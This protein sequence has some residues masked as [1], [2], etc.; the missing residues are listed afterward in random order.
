M[1]AFSTNLIYVVFGIPLA[2][3]YCNTLL[4]NLNARM[5][6]RGEATTL[7]LNADAE[8]GTVS[9]PVSGNTKV[10]NQNGKT[11]PELT[12]PTHLV[13]FHYPCWS[14]RPEP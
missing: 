10:E 3:L 6:L 1:H 5:Y 2:S 8:L 7:Q 9:S 12:S 14:N 13:S 11:K 4:A